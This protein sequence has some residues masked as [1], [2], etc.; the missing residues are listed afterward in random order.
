M[1]SHMPSS[2]VARKHI[3]TWLKASKTNGHVSISSRGKR[4]KASCGDNKE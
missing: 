1:L 3:P 2:K 4:K